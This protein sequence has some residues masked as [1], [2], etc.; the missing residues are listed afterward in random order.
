MQLAQ[1]MSAEISALAR[2]RVAVDELIPSE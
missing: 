2:L 1:T